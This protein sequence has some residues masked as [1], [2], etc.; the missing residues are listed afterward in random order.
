MEIILNG[1]PRHLPMG[2]SLPELLHQLGF[3]G[4]P[5]LVEIN[6][7][8]L[9]ASEHATTGLRAGDRVEIIQIVAGG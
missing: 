1:K 5:V 7:Q 8:A 4:R 9:L 2:S 3:D 6:Q